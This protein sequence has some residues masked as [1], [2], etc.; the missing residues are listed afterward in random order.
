VAL[1][2]VAALVVGGV[3]ATRAGSAGNEPR[4]RALT[5]PP[6]SRYAKA[7]NAVCAGVIGRATAA[8]QAPPAATAVSPAAAGALAQDAR[9]IDTKLLALPTQPNDGQVHTWLQ[10]W[11]TLVATASRYAGVRTHG[12]HEPALRA[13]LDRARGQVDHLATAD[14]ISQCHL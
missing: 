12:A 4:P 11:A 7:A 8:A 10:A 2:V 14:G 6:S 5:T 13:A 3:V 9:A 1:V